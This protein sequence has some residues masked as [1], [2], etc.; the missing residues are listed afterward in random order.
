MDQ[1]ERAILSVA[2]KEIRSHFIFRAFHF[3]KSSS[4]LSSRCKG[5]LYGS[6]GT[7]NSIRRLQRNPL[8]FHLPLAPSTRAAKGSH[9]KQ[10]KAIPLISR[11]QRPHPTRNRPTG[12]KQFQEKTFAFG[13]FVYL[14][15]TSSST[16]TDSA[17]NASVRSSTRC[18]T[19]F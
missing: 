6:S 9:G 3:V 5:I 2:L 16:R 19:T 11:P 18:L 7:C 4:A 8:S 13:W 15:R 1:V 14:V 12:T 17:T 10:T